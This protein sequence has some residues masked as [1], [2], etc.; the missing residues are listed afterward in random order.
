MD[1]KERKPYRSLT[2]SRHEKE[3]RYTSSSVESEDVKMPHKSYSSSETLK[4]YDQEPRL[5]YSSRVKEV[6]H[7]ESD[8]YCRP[9]TNFSLHELG[10]T[11]ATPQFTAGYHTEVGLSHRGYS[12]S[13]GSDVD[14]ETDGVTSPDN[15]MKLWG[16]NIKSSRSSCVS[17][18][19][20]SALTLTDTEQENTENVL[21][22]AG[23][24]ALS[25]LIFF[26]FAE[27]SS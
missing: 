20:N 9:G 18:R 21:A 8:E 11:E 3:R 12:L 15:A 23:D 7:Q 5:V 16:R 6:I 24:I 14:T 13:T 26:H 17:S 1:I 27:R 4:A 22:M 19:A 10:L 25:A 2:K